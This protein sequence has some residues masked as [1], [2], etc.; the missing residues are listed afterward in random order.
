MADELLPE[1]DRLDAWSF[2]VGPGKDFG[3]DRI[4]VGTTG[5][6]TVTVVPDEGYLKVSFGRVK[7]G[8][9]SISLLG[10]KSKARKLGS[11][12]ASL[13]VATEVEAIIC[14]TRA[15]IGQP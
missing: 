13:D 6:F 5:A 2:W 11:K 10:L 1:L 12:L 4:V 8:G 14:C 7:V 3:A 9:A 15:T